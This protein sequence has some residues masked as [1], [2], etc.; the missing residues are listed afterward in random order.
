[1]PTSRSWPRISAAIGNRRRSWAGWR[2]RDAASPI[3]G[4]NKH[5]AV[6]EAHMTIKDWLAVFVMA[7]TGTFLAMVFIVVSPMLPLV[8]GHFGGG[9][10]GAFV[11][12]WVLT[13][14]ST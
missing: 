5:Q 11:A 10:D 4:A 3:S 9:K 7:S 2:P 12:Q 1:M 8:A 6:G 13:M 14:P